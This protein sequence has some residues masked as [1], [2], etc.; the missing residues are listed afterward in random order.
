[1]TEL[2]DLVRNFDRTFV[3]FDQIRNMLNDELNKGTA[4]AGA[5]QNFPPYNIRKT[6][7]N[8]YVIELAVAGFGKQDI[9]IEL[10]EDKLTI[11][12]EL[13]SGAAQD[14][15]LFRG[16]A[17][18]NFLRTF[19]LNDQVVVQNASL[20]NGILKVFL[21]RIVPENKKP[22]SIKIEDAEPAAPEYL[23]EDSTL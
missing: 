20:V 14:E 6:D 9:E 3:G 16:I 7:D 17:F 5:P 4:F 13:K 2:R 21:E 15:Y 11:R 1:M 18:R 23:T 22:R 19:T 10:N 8:K 12:G